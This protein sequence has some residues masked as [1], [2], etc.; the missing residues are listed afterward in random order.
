MTEDAIYNA[1]KAALIQ[2]TDVQSDHIFTVYQSR[3]INDESLDD[4]IIM[5][6][7]GDI[8]LGTPCARYCDNTYTINQNKQGSVQIDFFGDKAKQ[9]ADA[10]VDSSRSVI[11]CDMLEPYGMKPLYCDE[12]RNTAVGL[13]EQLSVRRW[14]V[15]LDITYNTSLSVPLDTFNEVHLNIFKTEL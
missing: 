8:R 1:I 13:N 6:L 5:T 9:G 7:T 15:Q 14:T 2:L 3:Q 11:L 4:Y 10:I 12:A